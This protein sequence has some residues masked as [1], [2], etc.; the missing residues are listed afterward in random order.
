MLS[1]C[2]SNKESKMTQKEIIETYY[3]CMGEKIK[4]PL[5][6]ILQH[7]VI[8]L[9]QYAIYKDRN[10]MIDDIWPNVGLTK[11]HDIQIFGEIDKYMVKYKIKG[12]HNMTMSEYI[13]FRDDK[14]SKIEVYIGFDPKE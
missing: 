3:K 6:D 1:A 9:S 12:Q 5:Y 8:F 7:D 13:E 11:A 2:N 14:I 10:K 4:E